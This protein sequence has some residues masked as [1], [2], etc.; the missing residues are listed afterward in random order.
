MTTTSALK[1][2]SPE[3]EPGV[4]TDLDIGLRT[5]SEARMGPRAT[6]SLSSL[7]PP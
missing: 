7:G 5:D 1:V 2:T 6:G 4:V 3:N